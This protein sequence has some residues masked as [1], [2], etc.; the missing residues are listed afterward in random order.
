MGIHGDIVVGHVFQRGESQQIWVAFVS[1]LLLRCR[2]LSNF[3]LR[4]SPRAWYHKLTPVLLGRNEGTVFKEFKRPFSFQC[5]QA[6]VRG[7][8]LKPPAAAAPTIRAAGPRYL[9]QT[10][11]IFTAVRSYSS[12]FE[13]DNAQK[14]LWIP[15]NKITQ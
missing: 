5:V 2:L 1:S 11:V 10:T 7:L 6:H 12:G 13:Q 15:S 3:V 9:R 4:H 8:A 14:R